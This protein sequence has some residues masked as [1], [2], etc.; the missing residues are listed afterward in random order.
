M[1][2]IV[3]GYQEGLINLV[4]VKAHLFIIV[5]GDLGGTKLTCF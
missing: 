3:G 4:T 2:L 5:G 1:F